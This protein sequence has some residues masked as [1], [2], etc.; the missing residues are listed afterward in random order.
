MLNRSCPWCR[1]KLG[2]IELLV[3]DEH[4]PK[5]C[6]NCGNFLKTPLTNSIVSVVVPIIMLAAGLYIF[7]LDLLPLLSLVLLIPVLRIALAE[8]L[9]YSLNSTENVCLQCKR[10]NIEFSFPSS[11]ICDK[12]I[13]TE[14]KSNF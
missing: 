12:C 11:N 13:L 4:S 1:Q 6:K 7:D 14:K 8:P 9:K 5:K 2:V 3:L 10:T